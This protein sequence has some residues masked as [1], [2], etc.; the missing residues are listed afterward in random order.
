[1]KRLSL[2][3]VVTMLL[4]FCLLTS[5]DESSPTKNSTANAT[6]EVLV[7]E[8]YE[9]DILATSGTIEE[10]P[11]CF[12]VIKAKA[13]TDLVFQYKDPA[14]S[15]KDAGTYALPEKLQNDQPTFGLVSSANDV[16]YKFNEVVASGLTDGV[17]TFTGDADKVK[18]LKDDAGE[19][20]WY[21][22]VTY[23]AD[24]FSMT[25]M[26]PGADNAKIPTGYVCAGGDG[27]D[28]GSND[29]W[30]Y[31][32]NSAAWD[33]SWDLTA[34]D[35]G[36]AGMSFWYQDNNGGEGEWYVINFVCKY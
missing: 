23:G 22:E 16:A 21:G 28:D 6:A 5:C 31:F 14:G 33:L 3:L 24:S 34:G 19:Y 32:D 2:F 7:Q 29:V 9:G 35:Q 11:T 26:A 1:M 25:S 10:I 15:W 13:S 18:F 12:R 8:Y 20:S 30:L 4:S 17:V 36:W 27:T